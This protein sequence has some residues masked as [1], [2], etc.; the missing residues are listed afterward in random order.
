MSP[1]A[2]NI[3]IMQRRLGNYSG[4]K[5]RMPWFTT[6]RESMCELMFGKAIQCIE[7]NS[8]EKPESSAANVFYRVGKAI[9]SHLLP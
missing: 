2:K 6:K 9:V 4:K 8:L 5:L 3:H 7:A 1:N